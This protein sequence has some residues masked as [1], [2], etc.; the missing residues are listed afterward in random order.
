MNYLVENICFRLRSDSL[1]SSLVNLSR[2][3][4]F[5]AN[6]A[7]TLIIKYEIFPVRANPSSYGTRQFSFTD[8]WTIDYFFNKNSVLMF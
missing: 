8:F 2:S 4:L 5:S 7:S 6:E 1:L 3:C